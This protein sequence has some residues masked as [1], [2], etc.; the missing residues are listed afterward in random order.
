[1]ASGPFQ[2][3]PDRDFKLIR[4]YR[5]HLM[6]FSFFRASGVPECF[7]SNEETATRILN[8]WCPPPPVLQ[9][10][11]GREFTAEIITELLT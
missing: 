1:M 5:E 7:G 8:I 6:K 11:N 10:D 2:S 9:S 3:L 4:H